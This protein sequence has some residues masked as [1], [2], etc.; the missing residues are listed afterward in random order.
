MKAHIII[1]NIETL[2]FYRGNDYTQ[3]YG[4]TPFDG[5]LTPYICNCF[6]TTTNTCILDGEMVGY[7]PNLGTIGEFFNGKLICFS[8]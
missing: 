2:S 8:L 1:Y 7:D 4:A 3:T 6:S 5:N